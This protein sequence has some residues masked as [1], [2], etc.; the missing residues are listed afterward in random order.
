MPI[1]FF[2]CPETS[3]D[4]PM[5]KH[6]DSLNRPIIEVCELIDCLDGDLARMPAFKVGTKFHTDRQA[7]P[8]HPVCVKCGFPYHDA[9]GDW[10]FRHRC[11]SCGARKWEAMVRRIVEAKGRRKAIR[12]LRKLSKAK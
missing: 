8:P 2:P 11:A 12:A 3:G 6:P 10:L 1:T 5:S 7:A 9:D 4:V